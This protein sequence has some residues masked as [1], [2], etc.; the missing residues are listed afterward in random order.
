MIRILVALLGAGAVVFVIHLVVH[1]GVF[2]PV[3]LSEE[4]LGPYILIGR[5][6]IGPYHK[7]V[8]TLNAMES[9]AKEKGI[10]C[11][12]TFGEYLDDPMLVEHERLRS[13][14]GCALTSEPQIPED[15]SLIRKTLSEAR[16]LV[17]RFEGSPALGPLKVYRQAEK[18]L[19]QR[20]L[21]IVYPVIELYDVKS[22]TEVSTKY[23]FRL[24]EGTTD[25]P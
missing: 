18:W 15:P 11:N 20:K 25:S 24:Q 12:P 23:L 3:S 22:P 2:K 8:D 6:H 4:T 7:I 16:Y 17:A 10:P 19:A 1:L 5:P 21:K 14:G 9:W 13:I